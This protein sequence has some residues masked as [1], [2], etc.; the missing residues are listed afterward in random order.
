MEKRAVGSSV[1]QFID[2]III[3]SAHN[4]WI[5]RIKAGSVPFQLTAAS[6]QLAANLLPFGGKPAFMGIGQYA[7]ATE[8]SVVI[9]CDYCLLPIPAGLFQIVRVVYQIFRH[10]Q[11]GHYLPRNSRDFLY[12]SSCHGQS[13]GYDRYAYGQSGGESLLTKQAL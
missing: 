1:R 6:W 11:E 3:E 13:S 2:E 5:D 9:L 4:Q 7:W 10:L 12:L 8:K